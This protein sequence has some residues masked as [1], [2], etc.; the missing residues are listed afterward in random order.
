[1]RITEERVDRDPRRHP[2]AALGSRDPAGARWGPEAL[3]P[4][5]GAGEPL[6]RPRA[7]LAPPRV[8]GRRPGR[9]P[10]ASRSTYQRGVRTHRRRRALRP[11][12]PRH[13][14]GRGSPGQL[15]RLFGA[16]PATGC[17]PRS[18]KRRKEFARGHRCTGSLD[19]DACHLSALRPAV[20][21]PLPGGRGRRSVSLRLLRPQPA[22]D[23]LPLLWC[24]NRDAG[25]RAP[26]IG[27]W[28]GMTAE[29]GP[30]SPRLPA[31]RRFADELRRS[32]REHQ[33]G[34]RRLGELTG[35][36]S[37]AVAQWRMG[38]NLPRLDTAI[39]LA[40]CLSNDLLAEIV[41]EAR[42][43]TCE[44]CGAPFLNEGGAP[45]RYCGETCLRIAAKIR[46]A[47]APSTPLRSQLR[48]VK[49][50]LAATQVEL[51]DLKAS[52]ELMCRSC[53]PAGYCRT[54]ECP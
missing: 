5:P 48:A 38:R 51:V 25:R 17:S 27:G 21:G 42:T 30:N 46:K 4:S 9:S 26:G 32:M 54:T 6:Q 47:L 22:G 29:L 49:A 2:L 44:R 35:C 33:V 18:H 7:H 39:R 20:M 8:R 11:G 31:A 16:R 28:P 24:W 15:I 37:S 19:P 53:E 14:G 10:R 50:D 52:V 34:Q 41:R 40:E 3:Q 36:A 43:E 23:S 12:S 45:K 13:Q 1:M